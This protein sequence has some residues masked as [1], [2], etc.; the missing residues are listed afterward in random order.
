MKCRIDFD[1]EPNTTYVYEVSCLDEARYK[2]FELARA[3][4]RDRWTVTVGDYV[5]EFV[6]KGISF[7]LA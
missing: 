5:A 6:R 3:M 7:T 2:G 1:V 4:N